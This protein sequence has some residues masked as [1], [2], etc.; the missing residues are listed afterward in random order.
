MNKQILKKEMYTLSME[1]LQSL[2]EVMPQAEFNQ[3]L[4]LMQSQ[5]FLLLI[6][7]IVSIYAKYLDQDQMAYIVSSFQQSKPIFRTLIKNMP[8]IV[9]EMD[10]FLKSEKLFDIPQ[11][12]EEQEC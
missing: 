5:K 2:E 6:D 11:E 3:A 9:I 10:S 8:A 12:P 7:K 4:E 1:Y